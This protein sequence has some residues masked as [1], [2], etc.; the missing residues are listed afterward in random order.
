MKRPLF[1]IVKNLVT[2]HVELLEFSKK[3]TKLS[4]TI[5]FIDK[6]ELLDIAMDIVGFPKDNCL[7]FDN[8]LIDN[9]RSTRPDL[10]TDF[11]N[12]FIRDFWHDTAF[13]LKKKDIDIFVLKL[14]TDLDQLILEK[15]N[16]F[17]K[18]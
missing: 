17:V 18:D 3:L 5:D 8:N 7:E 1:D 10:R 2:K 6:L 13:E 9:E 15:P 4:V 14:F 12:R 11:E 16:L